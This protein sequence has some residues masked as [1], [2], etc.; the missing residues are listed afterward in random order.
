M[1]KPFFLSFGAPGVKNR[2]I[3]ESQWCWNGH[4]GQVQLLS[5]C[6]AL[7]AQLRWPRSRAGSAQALTSGLIPNLGGLVLS[8]QS[9]WHSWIVLAQAVLFSVGCWSAS[10]VSQE[11]LPSLGCSHIAFYSGIALLMSSE[12]TSRQSTRGIYAGNCSIFYLV[13]CSVDCILSSVVC[14]RK[15]KHST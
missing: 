6:P 15:V 8:G 7:P 2:A 3:T 4:W 10:N 13:F 12:S 11:M 1:K 9:C 5:C 14:L